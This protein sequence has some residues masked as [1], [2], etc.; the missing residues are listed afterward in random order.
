MNDT[1]ISHVF[2]PLP[3]QT[4]FLNVP[5]DNDI[6]IAL[7]Q[8]GFGS[9][10]TVSGSLLGV[11]LMCYFPGINGI[12]GAQNY[13]TLIKATI[14]EYLKH[15]TRFGYREKKDFGY[16]ETKKQIWTSWGSIAN[17][18]YL[19]DPMSFRSITAGFVE[20]EE[21]NMISRQAFRDLFGRLRQTYTDKWGIKIPTR[22]FFGH[23]NPESDKGWIYEAFFE[24]VK[25]ETVSY[26][27]EEGKERY[28]KRGIQ[29]KRVELDGEWLEIPYRCIIAPSI[30]NKYLPKTS[31][32]T[33][34]ESYDAEYYNINVLGENGDYTKGLVTKGFDKEKQIKDYIEVVRTEPLHLTCDFNR[35]PMSWLVAQKFENSDGSGYINFIHEYSIED[36]STPRVAKMF[37]EDFPVEEFPYII[38]N[39]DASG[40]Y[41]TSICDETNFLVL[42]NTLEEAGYTVEINVLP[43][44]MAVESRLASWNG[45]I[46]NCN[47]EHRIFIAK[48]CEKLIFNIFNFKYNEGTRKP[49]EYTVAEIR[50]DTSRK[51]YGHILHAASYMCHY[52]FPIEEAR[53]NIQ[54]PAVRRNS[55][56]SMFNVTKQKV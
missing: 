1:T 10:K 41:G 12:V 20:V 30:Q 17:I 48:Q 56:N 55:S 4:E 39:G 7:Y 5:H 27:E 3:A 43:Y 26:T 33:M 9:G 50:N 47:G 28:Y 37:I 46:K 13:G 49:R 53:P 44:N 29:M 51:W 19:E 22:R 2:S 6:D 38:L 25:M 32:A 21:M 54:Q 24:G 18:C 15:F 52:Y 34:K 14:P 16:N 11:M 8:G 23:T 45:M 36:T 40:N 35:D 31:I 42:K